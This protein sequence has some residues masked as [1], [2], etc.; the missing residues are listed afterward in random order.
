MIK[1]HSD[2][3]N[4]YKMAID[5]VGIKTIMPSDMKDTLRQGGTL[6]FKGSKS[7][8]EHFDSKVG[9]N[10]NIHSILAAMQE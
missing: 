5:N 10:A 9:D 8:F 1:N 4:A 2:L 3:G 7:L 6:V